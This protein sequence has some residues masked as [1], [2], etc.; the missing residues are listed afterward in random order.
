MQTRVEALQVVGMNPFTERSGGKRLVQIEPQHLRRVF[1][2]PRGAFAHVPVEG[3]DI[4]DPQ[5][6]LQPRLV[7]DNNRFMPAPLSKQR[8]ENERA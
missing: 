8:R 6:A 2:A 1:A 7:L 3:H 5:R 4:C